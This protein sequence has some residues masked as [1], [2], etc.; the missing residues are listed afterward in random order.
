VADRKDKAF[1]APLPLRALGDQRLSGL[2]LRTLGVV[3]AHDRMS[4][5]LG[6]GRGCDASHE[7]LA[8]EIGCN[9]INLGKSIKKLA[10]LGYV[11]CSRQPTDRRSH[12]YR[13]PA[14]LYDYSESLSFYQ[15]SAHARARASSKQIGQTTK[16]ADGIVCHDSDE[17]PAKTESSRVQYISQSDETYSVETAKTYSSEE[18]RFAARG[19]AK[20]EFGDN[21]GGQMARLER[22]LNARAVIDEQTSDG[23]DRYLNDVAEND[24]CEANRR[25][26]ERLMD[27]VADRLAVQ[28]NGHKSP[29]PIG[30]KRTW[31]QTI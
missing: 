26:A 20:I 18:A 15:P 10:E 25:R 5:K 31:P 9:Y 13:V 7:T 30:E 23:W 24:A 22:E 21:A 28:K 19:L 27:Q 6:S 4:L 29:G 2:D 1:S 16:E 14:H 8:A 17:T 12:V 3:A 11:E